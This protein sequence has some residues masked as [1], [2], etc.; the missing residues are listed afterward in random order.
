[1]P[2]NEERWKETMIESGQMPDDNGIWHYNPQAI[3]NPYEE[4]APVTYLYTDLQDKLVQMMVE[5]LCED[6]TEIELMELVKKAIKYSDGEK[7]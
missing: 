7:D 5:Y 1:M 6:H 2:T 4:N 3:E